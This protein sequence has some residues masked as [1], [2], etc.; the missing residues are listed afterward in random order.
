MDAFSEALA[1]ESAS[2]CTYDQDAKTYVLTA[3]E[4]VR[5][6]KIVAYKVVRNI[7]NGHEMNT[8]EDPLNHKT[9]PDT[10]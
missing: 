10:H 3:D 4:M 8:D 2:D 1:L 9:S 5:Y 6:A 7:S